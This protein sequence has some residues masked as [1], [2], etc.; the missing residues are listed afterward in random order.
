MPKYT[1]V[2][3]NGVKFTAGDDF[4]RG[5]KKKLRDMC[6]HPVG[7]RRV[8]RFAIVTV[9]NTQGLHGIIVSKHWDRPLMSRAEVASMKEQGFW[10]AWVNDRLSQISYV[11]C[12]LVGHPMRDEVLK[13]CREERQFYEEHM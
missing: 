8:G 13:D 1:Y 12:M 6:L 9:V 10:E 5:F 4:S 7:H 2:L 3:Y 11:E